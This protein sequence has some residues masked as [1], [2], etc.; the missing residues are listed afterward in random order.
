ML[1]D[2]LAQEVIENISYTPTPDQ[3]RLVD[4]MCSYLTQGRSSD[5]FILNGYAGTGK[6]TVIAAFTKMLSAHSIKSYILAPT[7]RAAKVVS[8]YSGQAALTIH[9]KIYRQKSISDQSFVLDFNRDKDAVYIVDEASMIG[10]R[11]GGDGSNFGSG[12]LLNDLVEYVRNGTNCRLMLVGDI[13]QLPPIGTPLSPALDVS[14]MEYYG[15]VHY[16]SMNDII[17]QAEESGVLMNATACRELIEDNNPQFPKF[18]LNFPDV[19]LLGGMDVIEEIENAYYRYGKERCMIITRSNKQ[20]GRFNRGVRERILFQEE[21]L[22]SNDL[23]MIVKNNYS[24]SKKE[25][26]GAPQASQQSIQQDKPTDFIANGDVALI[27][28]VRRYEEV[29]GFR[30]ADVTMWLSCDEEQEMDCKVLLDTI[31]SDT[32]ALSHAD[33]LKLMQSVEQDY[34][35]ITRKADRYKAMREDAY[36]NALQ[37]KFAYAITGHKSQGG[38]WDAVF[39][40]RMI[41]GEEQMT[42]ELLRW[43]YTAITRATKEL[44]FINF[45]ERFFVE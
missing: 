43:L 33:N 41:F 14:Y 30:F 36:L 8:G 3:E 23:V 1:A 6:S 29:H 5:I 2:H 10:N 13:A 25:E 20:A 4:A 9:K 32:P 21:E 37:I 42:V 44:Y 24:Y 7:G 38:E 18:N 17:R 11:G 22:S 12:D 39:I 34:A 16:F 15:N 19:K 31:G 28:R 27:R 40:D 26:Q 45:D 35:H